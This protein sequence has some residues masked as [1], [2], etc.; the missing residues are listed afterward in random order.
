[1]Q[2]CYYF[3]M[4]NYAT[5]QQEKWSAFYKTQP[6]ERFFRERG[7]IEHSAT[8]NWR[9]QE[10]EETIIRTIPMIHGIYEFVVQNDLKW[11]SARFQTTPGADK[12]GWFLDVQRTP[13]KEYRIRFNQP[14]GRN[15][16]RDIDQH[17][18]FND[19]GQTYVSRK[20]L[21][22]IIDNI[23]RWE[24]PRDGRLVLPFSD[25]PKRRLPTYDYKATY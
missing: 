14:D 3:C 20:E 6:L 19:L 16:I 25:I 7:L 8:S 22:T 9:E 24:R 4:T 12:A 17:G 13:A 21:G 11:E 2:K 23:E 5:A 15:L 1:M 10:S 18:K